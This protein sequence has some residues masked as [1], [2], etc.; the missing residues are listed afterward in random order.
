MWGEQ[1]FMPVCG[2]AVDPGLYDTA[3]AL[4]L[5]NEGRAAMTFSQLST[6]L[7]PAG[8][9]WDLAA[10]P[11]FGGR[12]HGR[13]DANGFFIWKGSLHQAEAFVTAAWLATTAAPQLHTV[14]P[15][16]PALPA[17]RDAYLAQQAA[18]YPWVTNWAVLTAALDYADG[19]PAD[20]WMPNFEAARA[21]INDFGA[22]I[23]CNPT[24]DV[25]AELERLQLD[26]QL[27]FNQGP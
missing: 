27:I 7:L 17:D 10:L 12:A 20:G 26:L 6:T 8:E 5:F 1:L 13:L 16:L 22:K 25:S 2:G 23:S 4:T 21:R 19:P 15:G 11:A 18:R 14:I 24:A 9:D 3:P